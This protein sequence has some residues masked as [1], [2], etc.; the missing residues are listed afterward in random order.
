MNGIIKNIGEY[1]S[2]KLKEFGT[3]PKGVDWNSEE[4]QQLRFDKLLELVEPG[5]AFSVLDFGCGF[6]SLYGYMKQRYDDFSYTGF[7]ISAGMIAEARK[8]YPEQGITW[9]STL[10]A[11]KFD[12]AIA[13][14][15]FNVKLQSDLEAWMAYMNETILTLNNLTT[16]GFSFNV[17]S[18]RSDPEKRRP[19]LFYAE[20]AYWFEQC[21]N[22]TGNVTLIHDYPL[23][24]F[25]LL[26]RK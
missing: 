25:T 2:G 1:Y 23:Y 18:M 24:E 5:S 13:S 16:K 20:P 14:G 6:G 12:Y 11:V 19:D 7:D 4:S 21:M 9:T 15:I 22:L 10:P 8:Q 3:T 17:L 26:V